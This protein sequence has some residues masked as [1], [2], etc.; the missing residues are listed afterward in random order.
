MVPHSP[1]V[2]H[3]DDTP[4]ILWKDNERVVRRGWRLDDNGKRRVVLLVDYPSRSY[5]DR[6]THDEVGRLLRLDSTW[7]TWLC[8]LVDPSSP[9][10]HDAAAG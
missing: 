7:R 1:S 3:S 9:S 10:T 4:E 8:Q 5:L 6:L 2:A